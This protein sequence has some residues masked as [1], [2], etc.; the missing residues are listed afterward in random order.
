MVLLVLLKGGGAMHCANMHEFA[1]KEKRLSAFMDK[2]GYEAVVIG[3]QTNFSW[4]S[5]GGESRVLITGEL[6]EA[7]L[8]IT[9]QKRYCIV[10]TMDAQR[11]MTQE[12]A[13]LGFE[14]VV[15]KWFEMSRE[16]YAH[17][18]IKGKKALSDIQIC[19]AEINPNKFYEL[20]YPM[21][22]QEILRYRKLGRDAEQ[23]LFDVANRIEVG[24]TTGSDV[25]TM[26]FCEFA[27]IKA[28]VTCMIIGVDEEISA[29][30]HTIAWA[31]PINKA[32]MLVLAVRREGLNLPITRMVYFGDVPDDIAKRFD[33]VCTIAASTIAS[34]KA[35]VKFTDISKMQ[36]ELYKELGY[37]EEWE[38]HYSGGITGYTVNDSSL[39]KDKEA[40][41][42][43]GQTFNWYITITGVNTEDTI[44][45]SK[46]GFEQ[47]TVNGIWPTK[48]YVF[49][50]ITVSIPTI[51]IR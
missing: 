14:P 7:V 11:I 22:D 24:S 48:D 2:H 19:N 45:I 1:V 50:G 30:R 13:G 46:D 10:N 5:C 8:V 6:G 4:I 21:T 35:G 33:S 39:C 43:D 3:T 25:E 36:K 29:W 41:M 37:E 26:L 16:E 17:K 27:K 49:Q 12:L 32:C 38:I 44:I 31:K 40:V 15:L 18:L 28:I 34:C 47:F 42:V 20:H 9:K 23:V 51:L